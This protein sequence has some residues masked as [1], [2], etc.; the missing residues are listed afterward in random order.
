M[1]HTCSGNVPGT[2]AEQSALPCTILLVP[3]LN[4]RVHPTISGNGSQRMISSRIIV[5]ETFGYTPSFARLQCRCQACQTTSRSDLEHLL[6]YKVPIKHFLCCCFC[7]FS[8]LLCTITRN[9]GQEANHPIVELLSMEYRFIFGENGQQHFA[10]TKIP[11]E[12]Q[13]TS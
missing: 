5:L 10:F 11:N 6:Q 4:T 7:F 13:R 12:Y 1:E 9:Y 2:T 3:H 8:L